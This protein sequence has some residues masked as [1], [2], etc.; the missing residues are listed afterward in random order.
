MN[1]K[2][3]PS[4]CR[5]DSTFKGLPLDSPISRQK[6]INGTDEIFFASIPKENLSF[7]DFQRPKDSAR[8]D[9]ISENFHKDFGVANVAE[10]FY[11]GKY[12]YCITDAQQ[13]SYANPQNSIASII[14]N[15][16][17]SAQGFLLGN[18]NGKPLSKDDHLW[19]RYKMGLDSYVW[20]FDTIVEYGFDPHRQSGDEGKK[21]V[22]NE[23]FV[24]TVG[25]HDSFNK[26]IKKSHNHAAQ[27]AFL[28]DEFEKL[29]GADSNPDVDALIEQVSREKF[30]TLCEIMTSVWEVDDFLP[31]ISAPANQ[32][33]RRKSGYRDIWFAMVD[34]IN[35]IGWDKKESIIENLSKGMFRKNN[36]GAVRQEPCLS[37]EDVVSHAF[38][39]YSEI[40]AVSGGEATRQKAY[41]HVLLSVYK[42]GL[43]SK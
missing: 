19:A 20:F 1:V 21:N 15:G 17:S 30:S 10:E 36:K 12:Y 11:N 3:D 41:K 29:N 25:L 39:Y 31:N 37:L 34:V 14:T 8:S 38:K 42:T 24:G 43:T 9:K 27:R 4:R 35:E 28:K 40:V 2:F 32:R 16:I 22:K 13:R 33:T 7:D 26:K 23:K 6:L 5:K 18:S